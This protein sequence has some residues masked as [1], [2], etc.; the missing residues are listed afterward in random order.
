MMLICCTCS[1]QQ[2]CRFSD[3]G[4]ADLT[5]RSGDR[6]PKSAKA[7]LY[8]PANFEWSRIVHRGPL[9]SK[10]GRGLNENGG[11]PSQFAAQGGVFADELM[12]HRRCDSRPTPSR[13]RPGGLA[14]K[15]GWSRKISR[16][17]FRRLISCK[18]SPLK[19]DRDA[20]RLIEEQHQ[21]GS[22]NQVAL[23]FIWPAYASSSFRIFG[24]SRR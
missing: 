24:A 23:G 3:A 13:T 12:W 15:K 7:R 11:R 8:N 17:N 18:V 21:A 1:R 9:S 6:R 5:T 4:G 14:R 10:S 19:R 16:K 22:V 20:A 2:L